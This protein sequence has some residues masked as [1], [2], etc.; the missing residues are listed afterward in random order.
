MS[1]SSAT[2]TKTADGP[3]LYAVTGDWINDVQGTLVAHEPL[4]GRGIGIETTASGSLIS[5]IKPP[6]EEAAKESWFWARISG[7]P[8]TIPN[9]QTVRDGFSHDLNPPLDSNGSPIDGMGGSGF[10]NVIEQTGFKFYYPFV[11]VY[12]VGA[13]TYR[14]EEIDVDVTD[15]PT[16]HPI[17]ES[18]GGRVGRAINMAEFHHRSTTAGDDDQPWVIYGVNI[19]G[20]YYPPDFRPIPVGCYFNFT[21]ELVDGRLYHPLSKVG[22]QQ[23]MPVV[24]MREFT[25]PYGLKV[26][27]F[28]RLGSHDGGCAPIEFDE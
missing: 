25:D 28:A 3:A 20:T 23:A 8:T 12:L 22:G 2:F 6:A 14:N 9:S 1:E 26:Y 5:L 10:S 24:R 7:L 27:E 15:P 16:S 11:E 17:P 18:E 19:L 4:P 13:R 21:D